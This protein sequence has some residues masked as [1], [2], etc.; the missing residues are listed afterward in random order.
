MTRGLL[1]SRAT[2]NNLL[3]INA[4][5]RSPESLEIYKNYRNIY[6]KILWASKKLYYKESFIKNRKKNLKKADMSTTEIRTLGTLGYYSKNG[7]DAIQPILR[8]LN[9]HNMGIEKKYARMRKLQ[10]SEV[11]AE[12]VLK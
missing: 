11:T 2:K 3:K 7:N 6:N 1:V 4:T 8:H 5:K 10:E 9:K 12:G